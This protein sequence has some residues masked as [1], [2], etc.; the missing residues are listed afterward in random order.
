M[1]LN[2]FL[3][4]TPFL[5]AEEL[6]LWSKLAVAIG[7]GVLIGLEREFS[8]KGETMESV[9]RFAGILLLVAYARENLGEEGVYIA[10]GI[11]GLADIDAITI[12]MAKLTGKE[13]AAFLSHNAII[14]AALANTLVKYG[15][16][17]V[18]GSKDMKRFS[19]YGFLPILGVGTIYLGIRMLL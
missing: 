2:A 8:Q 15:L 6:P 13:M 3:L 11:S 16:C 17:L 14:L 12:S 4:T 1:I 5:G 18:F 19:S 7:I 10:S 9:E